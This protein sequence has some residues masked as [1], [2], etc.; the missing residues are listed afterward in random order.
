MYRQW[1]EKPDS[2]RPPEGESLPEARERLKTVLTKLAKKHK[3]G[4]VALVVGQPLANVLRC[5]V[6]NREAPHVCDAD[7]V[8]SPL[9]EQLDVPA[10]V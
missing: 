1:L 8:K 4:R 6:Q 5:M 9:W 2:V 3:T 7:G 10:A